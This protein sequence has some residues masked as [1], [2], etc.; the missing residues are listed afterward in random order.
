MKPKMI[1]KLTVDIGMTVA[2]LLLMAYELIGQAAHEWIGIAMFVLFILHHILNIS[3]SRN[4]LK[5]DTVSCALYRLCL[6]FWCCV[7]WSVPW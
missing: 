2:L 5:E 7:Q 4:L 6:F 1:L 3:W